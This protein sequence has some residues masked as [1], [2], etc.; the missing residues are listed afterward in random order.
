MVLRLCINIGVY[1]LFFFLL[2]MLSVVEG[3]FGINFTVGYAI[4]VL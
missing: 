3:I 2:I 1:V 4:V